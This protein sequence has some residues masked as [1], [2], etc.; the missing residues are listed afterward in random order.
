MNRYFAWLLAVF[1][2]TFAAELT[3]AASADDITLIAKAAE[4]GSA[5]SQILLA[6]AYLNGDGGLPKDPAI[7]ARWFERA[8]IQGNGYAEEKLGD[9]Y[10]Q[11]LGVDQN[12]KLAFDWRVK[13]ANRG[14]LQVQVKLGKMY[15]DGVGVDKDA[16]KAL[17][18]FKRSAT[19]GNA[20]AQTLL[21]QMYHYGLGVEPDRAAAK[22]WFEKASQQ[23]DESAIYFIQLIE[24]IGYQIKEG[25]YNRLP[26]LHRLANDGD[27][28]V[29]YQLA[30][31]YEHG[32]GGVK[33]DV[34]VALDWYKRAAAGGHRMAMQTLSHIYASGLDGVPPDPVAA[35]EWEDRAKAAK[36]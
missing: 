18:W 29:Q 13:A 1:A 23:G 32:V 10:E 34:A 35:K 4:R 12:L 30:Q 31:R 9:L 25:W 19:E 27:L 20:E 3:L 24:S 21:G 17:Y 36:R 26:E 33:K 6:I 15:R 11:G 8:A 7:A 16:A 14:N 22:S 28:E 5:S 2:L